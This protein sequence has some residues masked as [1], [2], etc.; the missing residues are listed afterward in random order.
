NDWIHTPYL[1]RFAQDAYIFDRAHCGSFPTVPCRN[2]VLTGRWTLVYKPWAPLGADEITLP[3]LLNE[4]GYVTS[5]FVDTPHPF[6]PGFNYQR[7]FQAWELIRGQEHDTWSTSP[8]EVRLPCNPHK[9]RGG[10][11]GAAAKYLQNVSERH[12]EEDYFPAR[13]MR[14]AARWLERNRKARFFMYVDTFDPHEPWDPP[15]HYL[16]RYEQG[17]EGEEVIY[18]RY[19]RW[20]DFM[21]EAELKHC[22]NLYAGEVS[23]VDRWIGFLLERVEDLGLLEGTAII[24]TSDHGFYLG[25]HGYIGKSLIRGTRHQSLP[26]YPEVSRIPLLIRLPGGRAARRL[27]AFAQPIDLMPTILELLGVEV[28]ETV[29]GK[30]LLP[31]I[32]GRGSPRPFAVS[33]PTLSGEHVTIPHPTNRATTTTPDWAL[34]FGS[35][36]EHVAPETTQM[37]DSLAREIEIVEGPVGPELY[38]LKADPWCTQN[39]ITKHPDVA[40]QIHAQFVSFLKEAGMRKDHLPYFESVPPEMRG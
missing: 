22:R 13:T 18:P 20:A 27:H 36:V 25:E 29:Q 31:T 26:L 14:S 35:Q 32:E 8:A 3:E 21:T 16:E 15:A 1:D 30:S 7:G 10:A 37:V 34:V 5:L 40:R 28:P 33:S 17:Y 2:D 12:W 38:D 39:V 11:H 23:L 4:A 6:A 24:I 9:L 19:D